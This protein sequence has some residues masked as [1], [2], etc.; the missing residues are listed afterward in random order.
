VED[1]DERTVADFL[2]KRRRQYRVHLDDKPELNLLVGF[3]IKCTD[4]SD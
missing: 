2:R 3:Q 4:F 1:L